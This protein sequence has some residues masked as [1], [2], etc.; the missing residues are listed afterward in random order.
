VLADFGD[1]LVDETFMWRN[2]E[3]FPD[4]TDHWGRVV[5]PMASDW[6]RGVVTSEQVCASMAASLG[7]SAQET[8]RYV[9]VLC[10]DLRFFP[11]INAALARRRARGERQAIVTVN[12]D[13]FGRLVER[14]RLADAFDTIVTSC[15]VGTED[16]TA[17]CL[18][19]CEE[20]G[21]DPPA[22]VL[23][24]NIEANVTGWRAAG[25]LGYLFA[26][27]DAFAADVRRGAVPGFVAADARADVAG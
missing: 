14:Y 8:A 11:M 12:P 7:C 9:D 4:W 15:E 27:D 18:R 19:A 23:V 13:L 3:E 17:V 21:V 6:N 25:G 24:D 10:R 5:G 2:C 20:L 1:T 26:G 22:T 16:K